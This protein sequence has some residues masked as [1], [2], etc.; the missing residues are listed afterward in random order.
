MPNTSDADG[1]AAVNASGRGF[2][3]VTRC[4]FA[5]RGVAVLLCLLL[6]ATAVRAQPDA[7]VQIS[8]LTA[9]DRQ[10]MDRQ[11]QLVDELARRHLGNSCCDDPAELPLL[12]RLLD[13]E[14]VRSD[15]RLELQAMGIV[16]G[17]IL[18]AEL[19]MDWVIYEDRRGRSRALRLGDTSNYLFPA[20]M[21]SRRRE[22]GND[23]TVAAIY[24]RA[25]G[26]IE[27]RLPPKPY[28]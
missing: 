2:R 10:Y 22:A 19:G 17:D 23:E 13:E 26:A 12:Q 24:D 16:L 8:E 20:T 7:E 4:V 3:Q 14:V 18:G 27:P 21:I 5:V 28:Q 9:L 25:F 1:Q 15:Q 6:A 11:R